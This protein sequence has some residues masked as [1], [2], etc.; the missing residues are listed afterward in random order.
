MSGN[1]NGILFHE[2]QYFAPW[3]Y[4]TLLGSTSLPIL[5]TL[6]RPDS[7][8]MLLPA[9]SAI[10]VMV[11]VFVLLGV[12]DTAVYADR[13]VVTFGLLRLIKFT[14]TLSEVTAVVARKYAPI[15][16]FGGWGI[17]GF[18]NKRA[19]NM[20]GTFGAELTLQ[21]PT[22]QGGTKTS[23]MMIGSQRSEALAEAITQAM[24]GR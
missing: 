6:A 9:S 20:R 24:A 14:L 2:R 22:K 18:D 17:R 8:G 16:E 13:V 15:G 11:L 4:V 3:V 5:L 12:M 21:K 23:T 10:G 1:E 19:L 7:G